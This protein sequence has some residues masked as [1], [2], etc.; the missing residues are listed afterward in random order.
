MAAAGLGILVGAAITL[1][2]SK[3]IPRAMAAVMSNMMA[4][5]MS[6]EDAE[7]DTPFRECRRVMQESMMTQKEQEE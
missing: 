6:D 7:T 1:V 2:A 5:M 3:A 4:G